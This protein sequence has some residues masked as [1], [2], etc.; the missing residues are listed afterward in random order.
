VKLG[1]QNEMAHQGND[2]DYKPGLLTSLAVGAVTWVASAWA[3]V[4]LPSNT[5]FP[6]HWGL[7]GTPDR[8]GGKFEALALLPLVTL[9][10]VGLFLVLP[11]IEP[12]RLHLEQSWAAYTAVWIAVVV[13]LGGLQGAMLL[14]A[15][16]VIVETGALIT[17]GVGGLLIVIGLMMPRV[18]SNFMFGIR[19]PWTLTSE[20][21][22]QQTHRL[23]AWLFGAFGVALI[24]AALVDSPLL[25]LWVPIAGVVVLVVGL[26]G[27][28]YLIWRE[29]DRHAPPMGV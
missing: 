4:Q 21:S 28:S 17:A 6:I 15:F 29:D 25:A 11:R 23:G 12:R 2:M 20:R 27:Y 16:G 13:L 1:D 5:T 3:W 22:W 10:V 9:A 7:A 8:Y 24:V 18:R 19:T 14:S 26:F